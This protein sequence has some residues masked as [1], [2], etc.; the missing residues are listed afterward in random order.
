MVPAG[1]VLPGYGQPPRT[2]AT[3]SLLPCRGHDR[4]AHHR[5]EDLGRPRRHAGSRCPG[6]PRGR[7]APHPRGDQPAGL[8]GAPRSR[9]ARPP[10]GPDGGDRGPLDPDP[11]PQPADARLHGG[12]AGQA[13]R[14]ELRRIRDPAPRHRLAPPGDR[15]RHRPAAR[16]DAARHD[17][18]LRGLAH[19][20]ARCLRCPGVR[21]RDERGRDGA[22]DPD[23]PPAGPEDLRGACR[24]PARSR[25]EQQGHHPRAHRADRRRRR[26]R[27]RLRIPR[28]G[29]PGADHG[30]AHD[31]LQHEHRRRGAGRADRPR[32]HHLRVR[33]RPAACAA[34]RR[35]GRGG[36]AL[37]AAADRRRG[38]VRQVDHDRRRCPRA[39]GHLR[40][41][42]GHGHPHHQPG[43]VARRAGRPEPAARAGARARVHGPAT[44]AGDPRPEGRRRVHRLVHERPDQRPAAG[45]R[46][47]QGPAR[48]RRRPADG[49]AR[50]GRGE[51]RG[52]ARR[53]RRHL[54]GGRRRLAR[55]RLLD[56]HRDERRPAA[57][58][59]VRGEHLEPQL[60][61]PPGQGRSD[62]P[63]LA[64]DRGRERGE[65]GRV[66]SADP[67]RHRDR[68][69]PS[70]V[71][72][73]WPSRGGPSP[74]R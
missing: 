35:V 17:D 8:L 48:R 38:H 54:Q 1:V 59:A 33:P 13:A 16:A 3:R 40:H 31:D 56:V 50:L 53:D 36:R 12:G 4:T 42:P 49:H 41:E 71:A 57:A 74:A 5:P 67:A 61:G 44:R 29:D 2:V 26:D 22:R 47:A 34:G 32:R 21:D 28:R 63:R 51:A 11:R 20:H 14:D 46:S 18:R 70:G 62:V 15:P 25:R 30:A 10:A 58:R 55:V 68:S 45:G 43:P 66:R 60:R 72:E 27:P 69:P 73:P 23:A 9:P 24:R 52:G 39:D 19:E 7:P 37:A 65:R 64:A 6:R